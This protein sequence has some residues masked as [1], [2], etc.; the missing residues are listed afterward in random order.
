MKKRIHDD[1][2]WG[3]TSQD[4]DKKQTPVISTGV[5]FLE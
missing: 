5:C 3:L 4:Q 1:R 2:H